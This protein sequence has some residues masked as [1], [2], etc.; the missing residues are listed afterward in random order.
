MVKHG[1]EILFAPIV[2]LDYRTVCQREPVVGV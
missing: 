2:I 1:H